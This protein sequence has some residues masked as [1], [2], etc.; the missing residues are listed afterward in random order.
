MQ[1]AAPTHEQADVLPCPRCGMR[2]PKIVTI[3]PMGRQPGL[4]AYECTKCAYVMSSWRHAR[5]AA[6]RPG[7]GR[8]RLSV[9]P[10]PPVFHPRNILPPR[11]TIF[12]QR[13]GSPSR[14]PSSPAPTRWSN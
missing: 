11:G 14:R 9:N 10:P 13:S 7:T 5:R 12:Q 6:R 4:V 3:A 2:M 1:F 8:T